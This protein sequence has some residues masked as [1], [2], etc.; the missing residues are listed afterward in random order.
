MSTPGLVISLVVVIVIFTAIVSSF[1]IFHFCLKRN[2][3]ENE[4]DSV[5]KEPETVRK[6][7]Q[8]KRKKPESIKEITQ[9]RT[10]QEMRPSVLEATDN[11]HMN[12]TM[13][14][15]QW[16]YRHNVTNPYVLQTAQTVS[17]ENR[18]ERFYEKDKDGSV[19]SN[20]E[21]LT[22]T[23]SDS[24][25]NERKSRQNSREGNARERNDYVKYDKDRRNHDQVDEI[26][27]NAD[28]FDPKFGLVG[29]STQLEEA[30]SQINTNYSQI[31][32]EG[33]VKDEQS[34]RR[35]RIPASWQ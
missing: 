31:K 3:K 28:P 20:T 33:E 23:S 17:S 11:L 34:S 24:Y 5:F 2:T 8:R 18:Q 12:G 4:E 9:T 6:K 21:T 7:Q 32:E 16:N 15:S 10:N 29:G 35:P 13:Q 14:E 30:R 25:Q 19:E 26:E 22:S 27:N 1:L